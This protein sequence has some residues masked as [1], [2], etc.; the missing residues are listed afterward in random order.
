MQLGDVLRVALGLVGVTMLASAVVILLRAAT[1]RLHVVNGR[2]IRTEMVQFEESGNYTVTVRYA[3]SIN[4]ETYEHAQ[5][6]QDVTGQLTREEAQLISRMY[7]PNQPINV[8]IRPDH[9]AESRL[10]PSTDDAWFWA[11]LLVPIGALCLGI[12]VSG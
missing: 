9:P 4:N 3:Y 11:I 5:V 7:S 8:Y 2:I 12:A 6:L 10:D 1:Q